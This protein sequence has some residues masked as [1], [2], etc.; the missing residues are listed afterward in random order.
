[1][2]SFSL[3][4]I[5]TIILNLLIVIKNEIECNTAYRECFNCSICGEETTCNCHWDPTS[6]QCNSGD[7]VPLSEPFY[8]YFTSCTDSNSIE[9]AKKYCGK[10]TLEFD[11]D[12]E[13]NIIVPNNNGI[14]GT[15]KLFCE[16]TY[17]ESEDKD[18]YYTIKYN[19]EDARNIDKM[20]IYLYLSF[21]DETIT[22][23]YLS[24]KSLKKDFNNIK[25]I[26]VF[27]YFSQGLSSL[28]FE[29]SIIRIGDK[30]KMALYLAIGFIILACLLC[31]LIIY[32]LSKKISHNTRMRQR[33]LVQLAMLR[34]TGQPQSGDDLASSNSADIEE[35]N[36]KKIEIL[37]KTS[38]AAKKYT[39]VSGEKE[40]STCT[41]C[42]EEF[43]EKKS[44]VSITPCNH[45]FHYKCLS[46]WL[47]KNVINPKCPNCN[48]NLVKD[49]D[50]QKIEEIQAINVAR[51]NNEN[52][53]GGGINIREVNENLNTNDNLV[54]RNMSNRHRNNRIS[55][56]PFNASTIENRENNNVIQEVDIQN[57]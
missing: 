7:N 23:G 46:N 9:I 17:T 13:I 48:Y 56:S 19:N 32:Y 57:N 34:Q 20:Y 8:N 29:L 41:I 15:N 40:A 12:N 25:E 38:L 4:I 36:R 33:T 24:K 16:Y 52:N 30:T 27:I 49:F 31:A 18:N 3:C 21:K 11:E 2:S 14:F 44:K 39:K 1:M 51:R 5:I 28:P 54:T 42:I 26:K 55:L 47:I 10:T 45:I 43:K 53:E 37:L 6:K 22:E 50:K 35:E